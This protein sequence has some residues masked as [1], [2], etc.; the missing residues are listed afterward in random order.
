MD[1]K[2]I[3]N[4]IKGTS[5]TT[6]GTI[7]SM[8]LNF[9]SLFFITRHLPVSDFGIYALVIAISGLLNLISGLGLE[10]SVVKYIS[11]GS[12][13]RNKIL[14]PALVLKTTGI[15]IIS[16]LFLLFYKFYPTG[17]INNVWD[18]NL[19]IL[20]LFIIGTFR[21]FFYRV[22]QG[23]NRFV[24]YT[25]VQISSAVTR[26]LLLFILI[27]FNNLTLLNLLYVEIV[28]ASM[29]V[30]IQCILIPFRKYWEGHIKDSYRQILKFSAPLYANNII[31]FAYERVGLF[32]IGIF[33]TASSV[34]IFD[35]STRL[36]NAFQ[37]LVTS[38]TIVFFPNIA[39]LFT[40]PD[41]KDAEKLINNSLY[42]ITLVLTFIISIVFLWRNE[43]IILFFSEKYIEAALPMALMMLAILLRCQSNILG[44]SI[45]SAGYSKIPMKV[46]FVSMTVG[47]L[48]NIL[49]VWQFGYM[50]AVFAAIILNLVSFLQYHFYIKKLKLVEITDSYLK[51]VIILLVLLL[52]IYLL[53]YHSIFINILIPILFI[54]I[55]M[56]SIIKI[57]NNLIN[58]DINTVSS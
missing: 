28:T 14:K 55:H 22:L 33:L 32:T 1:K 25:S 56:N 50:G 49:L 54:I 34:A 52:P 43:L 48:S 24:S 17:G 36:P 40:L 23:L 20:A 8:G 45:V 51:P 30:T 29:A 9:V 31:T 53:Q 15:V 47:I 16:L 18:F 3:Q 42:V 5:A 26:I 21:E 10:I 44:L 37:S 46:N 4:I 35:L 57:K 12:D 6:L 11:E 19:F 7:S 27:Y 58:P 39:H 38:F 41:K 2:V 13:L